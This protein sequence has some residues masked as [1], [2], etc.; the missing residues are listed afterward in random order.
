VL[1]CLCLCAGSVGGRLLLVTIGVDFM[2]G[3]EICWRRGF[4]AISGMF[5]AQIGPFCPRTRSFS[6]RNGEVVAVMSHFRPRI[7]TRA[8]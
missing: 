8:R 5:P 7:A 3:P 6:V 1:T 2:F 4:W